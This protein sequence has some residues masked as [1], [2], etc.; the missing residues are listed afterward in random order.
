MEVR[1][2][3]V[4]VDVP[5]QDIPSKSAPVF[6]NPVMSVNRDICILFLKSLK[7]QLFCAD[8]LAGSGV[9]ALRIKKELGF[10]I[11]ANDVNP[12][13]VK[14]IKRNMK[15]NKVKI[16]VS[17]K[18]S[19][20]FLIQSSGFDYIDVDP[21]GSPNPFLDLSIK[22]LS[23]GGFIGVTATD[24][25]A[26][27][28]SHPK[29]G[30]RKYWGNPVRNHCMHEV[31][32]RLL[33]RKIQLIGAQYA[34]ALVPVFVHAHQHFYR[35]YLEC[36]KGKSA[37]D[38]L[39]KKHQCLDFSDD[40]IISNCGS[41]GPIY[42]GPLWDKKIVKGM[43][44]LASDELESLLKTIYDEARIDTVCFFDYYKLC[45]KLK[46][47]VPPLDSLI[48]ILKKNKFKACPT[49]FNYRGLR[50]DASSEQ[51]VKS[52]SLLDCS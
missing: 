37:V 10:D 23:R 26:L 14:A 7:K 27:A 21:F 40:I 51:I 52:L 42:T 20:E 24:T 5:K 31:G 29:A 46:M 47:N 1:E 36:K 12:L 50:S 18:T 41:V 19:D 25:S 49:H 44:D 22:R 11:V 9:R 45:S 17:N 8:I 43:L 2:G 35:V 33:V 39:M 3:S 4:T 15:K 13:A 32:V 38:S 48:K 28:G 30:L 34:K 6:F 16:G